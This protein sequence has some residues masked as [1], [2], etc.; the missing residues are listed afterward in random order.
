[1][2]VVLEGEFVAVNAGRDSTR[3]FDWEEAVATEV[4]ESGHELAEDALLERSAAAAAVESAE[5]IVEILGAE[6]A[7][8]AAAADSVAQGKQLVAPVAS[9]SPLQSQAEK[10]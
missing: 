9:R 4:L 5:Q 8:V 3:K 1:M 2:A 6:F 10:K 7:A